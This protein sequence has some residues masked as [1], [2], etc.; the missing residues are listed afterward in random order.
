ML[1][2]A[3]TING[4]N[5]GGI[6]SATYRYASTAASGSAAPPSV[7]NAARARL[8]QA[9]SIAKVRSQQQ[10]DVDFVLNSTNWR[11]AFDALEQPASAHKTALR[12]IM[13]ETCR[14][15]RQTRA[16]VGADGYLIDRV[17]PGGKNAAEIQAAK[18]TLKSRSV[19]ARCGAFSATELED[20][21]IIAEYR[22]AAEMGDIKAKLRL[23]AD[24][25]AASL[26]PGK[27][28]L[29]KVMFEAAGQV[30]GTAKGLTE[31]DVKL[32][33]EAF[34]SGDPIAIRYAGPL[35]VGSYRESN[36]IF[37]GI[38][39]PVDDVL[40]GAVWASLACDY[41]PNCGPDSNT[42]LEGCAF[43]GIC[44][45]TDVASFEIAHR[46][47]ADYQPYV[48]DLLRSF[49]D[50]IERNDFSFLQYHQKPPPYL[51][52]SFPSKPWLPQLRP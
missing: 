48:S 37:N 26:K 39:R 47:P 13:L 5:S 45:A 34:Q 1:I 9:A 24:S 21:A 17:I 19:T 51:L 25:L 52:P 35:L 12:A 46:V 6:D 36:V 28:E 30:M 2:V 15:A 31:P 18:T 42:L 20:N 27:P 14:D 40:G 38:N 8:K 41:D 32:L 4:L 33:M 50:A 23:L 44:D 43:S 10:L 7:T 3:L 29:D 11:Q 16:R 49:R 22:R